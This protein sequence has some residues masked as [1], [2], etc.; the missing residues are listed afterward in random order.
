MAHGGG[1]TRMQEL[2]RQTVFPLLDEDLLLDQED[3]A[4]FSVDIGRVALTTDSYVVKPLF[5][6][7]GDIGKLAVC[8]TVN[9]LAMRGGEPLYITLGLILEEGL[10]LDVLERILSSVGFW[11]KEAGVRVVAGDTK[12]VERGMADGIYINTSGVGQLRSGREVSIAGATDGDVLMVNGFIGDHGMAVLNE[13]EG[14]FTNS[15]LTSDCAPLSGL[16]RAMQEAGEVHSL[17]DPTR[18][19]LAAALKEMAR[20]SSCA[21]EIDEGSVPIRERV[22]AACEMLGLDPLYVANEGK[23]LAAVPERDA[24]AVLEAM[25]ANPRG[26]EAGIIGRII[27]G[28]RGE[29]SMITSLGSHRLVRAPSGEQLPRIC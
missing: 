8:G 14:L 26:K 29:V 24:G 17:R 3:A 2:L 9:D 11:A 4:A 25:R 13:R 5:F 16:V 15:D 20:A 18:G 10:H 12:V 23:L 7:G 6:P 21:F 1:G 22:L 27:E 28:R 19:G